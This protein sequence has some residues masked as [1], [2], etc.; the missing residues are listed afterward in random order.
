[1]SKRG[2]KAEIERL[3]K[4]V[5]FHDHRYFVLDDPVIT[6]Q[7]YDELYHRLEVLENQYPE[8]LTPDSPTQRVGGSPLE[9]FDTITH[10]LKMLSLDNT[11]NE[12]EVNDFLARV[13]KVLGT[14]PL[15]EVSLK[16]DGVAVSLRYE[17]GH[18][19]HGATRGD[20]ITG[21]D[22]TQNLRTIRSIPLVLS[23]TQKDLQ[24]IEVRGE[25]FLSKQSFHDLNRMREKENLP[26]FAN[27]R[28]AAAGTLKLLD[29][30]EVA[31]RNLD[32]FI[33]TVPQQPGT[34]FTSHYATL[35]HL[36]DLG[37]K[38]I[39]HLQLCRDTPAVFQ[40]ITR[41][42]DA[43]EDLAYEVDGLVI[44]VDEFEK[45]RQ[46]GAT[47]KNPRWAIA[48][49]YPSRQAITRVLDIV[50]QVGRTGRI[51]P[52]AQL[53][54][55]FLSGST[56]SRATLHNEDEILRKDIR[57]NDKVVIEKGGEIIPKVVSVVDARRKNRGTPF[58]FP[59]ECPV[60]T[61]K[62]VRLPDEVDWRCINTNC[63]AQIKG[64]LLHFASRQAMDIEG[65]GQALVDVLVD[66]KL[67]TTIDGIYEL[68]A[69]AI[70]V[71]DR[72]GER[73]TN[74]LLEAITRSKTV[75][76]QRVLYAIGIPNVGSNTAHLLA[77]TYSSIDQLMQANIEQLAETPGIGSII[78][79][80]IIDYFRNKS[81]I[82]MIKNLKRHGLQF[83]YLR[84]TTGTLQGKTFVF[85][86]HLSTLT[87]DQAQEKIREQGGQPVSSVSARTDYVVVGANPG[88]KYAR[89][90]KLGVK[91]LS[92]EEF[93]HLV[94]GG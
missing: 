47:S 89:A 61:Q 74:K 76:F 29:P 78:G 91:T 1:M 88:S 11:Y 32:I 6:D 19:Q 28:N 42:T 23:T 5:R 10:K 52:V 83:T 53:E 67:V 35:R 40:A 65:L 57:I 86:G 79:K 64:A 9:S 21:D 12:D 15:Y 72:M 41:W 73:S 22:I 50:L 31:R 8:Y 39:P 44:K 33:H 38:I 3:R 84:P 62:I 63:P 4:E 66:K 75:G 18:L 30:R 45:R 2:I 55:V 93:L 59:K 7:E 36:A 77:S 87:R 85:T 92:E 46:L 25:V 20:G 14:K 68:D 70:M 34:R 60:C 54:P 80:S 37:F 48:Y 82:V 90:K 81:N 69:P 94:R 71:L 43:R 27:P 26:L 24:A 58:R 16:V 51:T 49:K 56:I 17:R 13:E